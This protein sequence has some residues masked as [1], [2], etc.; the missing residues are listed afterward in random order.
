MV[1]APLTGFAAAQE[2]HSVN[3]GIANNG[4]NERQCKLCAECECNRHG[5]N[6]AFEQQWAAA[7]LNEL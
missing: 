6:T 3:C 1:A 7:D 4:E 5:K 2:T